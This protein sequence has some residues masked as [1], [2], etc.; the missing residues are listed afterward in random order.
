MK[1]SLTA[2]VVPLKKS[3]DVTATFDKKL[4]DIFLSGNYN[5]KHIPG[6]HS[7]TGRATPS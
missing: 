6:T 5:I 7:S 4:F 2:P 3:G 1:F